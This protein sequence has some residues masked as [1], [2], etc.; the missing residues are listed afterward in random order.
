M[1]PLLKLVGSESPDYAL[2]VYLL[3]SFTENIG[4]LGIADPAD[5][6]INA[7]EVAKIAAV[8]KR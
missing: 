6:P 7:R 2:V 4:C 8:A 5:H 1:F 3:H